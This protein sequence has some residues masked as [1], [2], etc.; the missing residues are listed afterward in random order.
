MTQLETTNS[1]RFLRKRYLDPITGKDDWRLIHVG[2]AKVPVLGFFGQPLQAGTSSATT[3]LMGNGTGGASNG[4]TM[5]EAAAP[6]AHPRWEVPQ[7]ALAAHRVRRAA[8]AQRRPH[9]SRTARHERGSRYQRNYR[10]NRRQR[11]NR[12]HRLAPRAV[13]ARVLPASRARSAAAAVRARL[14]AWA[15][16]LDKPSL[17]IY[18]KQKSTTNGSSP[19]TPSKS[20]CM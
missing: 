18:H 19:M 5:V 1:I 4:S 2:E 20:R 13:S 6:S 8:T 9:P 11:V 15:S 14:S 12:A 17:V 3:G 16:P 10:I 7:A